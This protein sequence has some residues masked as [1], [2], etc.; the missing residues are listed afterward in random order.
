MAGPFSHPFPLHRI[1][2]AW[3]EV[4]VEADPAE[5][6]ALA[7]DLAIPAI[8]ALRARYRVRRLHDD[9][10]RVEGRLTASVEQICVVTLDPFPVEVDEPVEVEFTT[11][12]PRRPAPDPDA[13]LSP[14]H[15]APDE[16]SGDHLD[17]G[18]VTAEFLALGLDPYPKKPGAT[19]AGDEEEPG[20]SPF[21]ALA[22]I[23]RSEEP[24]GTA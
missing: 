13:W 21:A 2:A 18:A 24:S 14:D 19:F 7:A 23:R 1:T 8:H 6:A 11:P 10:I 22:A 20:A 3:T 17:F 16:L 4:S 12:D 5:R 9:R 15:D